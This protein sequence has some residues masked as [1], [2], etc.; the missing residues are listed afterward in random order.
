MD[1]NFLSAFNMDPPVFARKSPAPPP[2]AT[3]PSSISASPGQSNV[4]KPHSPAFS[5][6]SSSILDTSNENSSA[7]ANSANPSPAITPDPVKSRGEGQDEEPMEQD[8]DENQYIGQKG[9][10]AKK[11]RN[12]S[13][14]QR[15]DGKKS[16]TIPGPDVPRLLAALED[17]NLPAPPLPTNQ[18]PPLPP[19]P[20]PPSPTTASTGSA[21]GKKTSRSKKT[22]LSQTKLLENTNVGDKMTTS[23]TSQRTTG[24]IPR[25][26]KIRPSPGNPTTSAQEPG[27][28]PPSSGI[29]AESSSGHGIS[30]EESSGGTE[31]LG[32]D[33]TTRS[34]S[35]SS[36][37]SSA[38]ST[39]P[40]TTQ[41]LYN[42]KPNADDNICLDITS[43]R[44]LP[45]DDKRISIL[46]RK[47]KGDIEG[48]VADGSAHRQVLHHYPTVFSNE[49]TGVPLEDAPGASLIDESKDKFVSLAEFATIETNMAETFHTIARREA[50]VFIIVT[51][52]ELARG[53]LSWDIPSLGL[54]QDFSNDFISRAFEGD[55]WDWTRS[56]IRSGRWGKVGTIILSSSNMGNLSEFRR[57]FALTNYKGMAFD[58]FPKD[59][60]TA[61]ADVSILLRASM[62][63]FKTEMIPKIL[64]ARNQ[65]AIAGSLRILSTRFHA[66]ED[67]PTKG[68]QRRIGDPSN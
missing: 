41:S 53:K 22:P 27:T 49:V 62:K 37:S 48:K 19:P 52:S 40:A 42:V 28:N 20:P 14:T 59:V 55:N 46:L 30:G 63:T 8:V 17:P 24:R 25:I 61:K 35:T 67:N 12:R 21:T 13:R 57:Q 51:R 26:P 60:L 38:P 1:E 43:Y 68:N 6:P 4:T 64:F 5:T 3:E 33:M 56:Y 31:D 16:T 47:M 58:T 32:S 39:T 44:F 65:D 45:E 54:C 15:S 7:A 10:I 9:G 2:P 34:A 23:N 11:A 50:L 29:G 66:A 36:S 18:P